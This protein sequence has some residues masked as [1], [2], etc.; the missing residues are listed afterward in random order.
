MINSRGEPLP[1]AIAHNKDYT[2]KATSDLSGN[3]HIPKP[4]GSD[5]LYIASMGYYEVQFAT[6]DLITLFRDLAAPYAGSGCGGGDR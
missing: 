6:P 2:I 5:T 4:D 3:I 1:A